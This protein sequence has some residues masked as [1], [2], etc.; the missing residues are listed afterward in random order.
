M[1]HISAACLFQKMLETFGTAVAL[2]GVWMGTEYMAA[3]I[4]PKLLDEERVF[5]CIGTECLCVLLWIHECRQYGNVPRSD[6][7]RQYLKTLQMENCIDFAMAAS[8]TQR[9]SHFYIGFAHMMASQVDTVRDAISN[10]AAI[11]WK[12]FDRVLDGARTAI[13]KGFLNKDKMFRVM[14][15]ESIRRPDLKKEKD[16]LSGFI[17]SSRSRFRTSLIHSIEVILIPP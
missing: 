7:V 4:N 5:Y 6:D 2:R 17:G 12:A 15:E 9:I 14:E 11:D 13:E 1:V 8:E 10:D 3:K 16:R